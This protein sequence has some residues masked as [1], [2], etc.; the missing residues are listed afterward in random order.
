M[1]ITPET[2]QLIAS[3]QQLKPHYA[4]PASALF[5]DFYCQCRQGCD[6]LFP[7]TVRETVR[8]VDILQWFF[9]C[10][11]RGQPNNLVRLMWKDVAGP[12]LAEYMADEKIEQQLQA[13][14]TTHLN[15]E[16]ESW[17]RTMT[18]SGNVKLLL[19]DLL[20]EIHQVEQSCAKSLT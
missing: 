3:I 1:D 16:L 5:L 9:E 10:A 7:P 19:K 17:D 18:S 13:A 11:E 20:N 12:T 15:Q 14:F 4:D 8:L 2:K 6:Y